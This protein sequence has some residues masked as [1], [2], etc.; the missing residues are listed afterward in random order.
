MKLRSQSS[1]KPQGKTMRSI[2]LSMDD[3]E[4]AVNVY[5]HRQG[6]LDKE[7]L[8]LTSHGLIQVALQLKS[9]FVVVK[10]SE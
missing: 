3:I 4:K 6:L 5:L 1:E 8:L 2:D 7:F 10:E 9:S